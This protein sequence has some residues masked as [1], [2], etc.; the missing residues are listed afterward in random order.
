LS[1]INGQKQTQMAAQRRLIFPQTTGRRF[2][3]TQDSLC[4]RQQTLS[5]SGQ[6]HPVGI[7]PQ[8]K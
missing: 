7:T 4:V 3:L 2:G 8:R 5:G 1:E 6:A